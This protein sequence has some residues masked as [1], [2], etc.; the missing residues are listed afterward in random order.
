MQEE[1][2]FSAHSQRIDQ[3]LAQEFSYSRAF[4]HHI[5]TRGGVSVNGKIVKK[6]Y[7]LKLGDRISIDDLERYVSP[8][9]LAESPDIAIPIVLDKEDYLVIHKPK[10][11][12]S[13]PNSIWDMKTPSVVWFLYHRYHDLPS[14]GNFVRAGIVHRL[15]KETDGLMIVA[16]TERGLAHFTHLFQQKSRAETLEEKEAIPLKK[17]YLA[18]CEIVSDEGRQCVSQIKKQIEEEGVFFI[19]KSVIPKVPHPIIKEWI[20]KILAL[21]DIWW[22][23]EKYLVEVEILT[24]RTH[25]IRYHLSSFWLPIIGDYLYG[26]ESDIP[27]QLTAYALSFT[28]PDGICQNLSL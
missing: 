20:T 24:G 6:S 11:V 15:D 4:F 13:H 2:V 18:R 21:K 14:I 5:I 17:K 26:R 22:E 19:R 25:Q 10:G 27:L 12:L 28:D 1:I 23:K 8:V 3:W 7:K 16:K 9:M